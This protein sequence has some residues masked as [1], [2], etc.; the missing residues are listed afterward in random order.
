MTFWE[1]CRVLWRYWVVVVV[2]AVCTAG[3][4]LAAISADPVYFARTALV[5]Q[6]PT[7]PEYPNAIRTQLEAVIDTAG[8]VAKRVGGPRK[9]TKYAS[10]EVTLVGLGVRDGWS[11]KLR[12]TGGQWGSNFPVQMLDL[13]VVGPSVEVVQARQQEIINRAETE[14]ESI[15]RDAGVDPDNYITFTA[16]PRSTVIYRV[17]GN[18]VRALAMTLLLGVGVTIT[19]ALAIDRRRRERAARE[20]APAAPQAPAP[21]EPVPVG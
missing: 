6:A 19:V 17:Q 2:G 3:A 5:F 14:L 4:G 13:D 7:T 16:S 21:S 20:A 12:D 15:Q 8:I 9:I 1:L 10:P 18:R 11:L